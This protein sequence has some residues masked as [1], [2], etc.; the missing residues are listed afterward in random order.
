MV[1]IKVSDEQLVQLQQIQAQYDFLVKRY[2]ELH[3]EA[4]QVDGAMAD[5]II[6]KNDLV[7]SLQ[8]EFGSAGTIDLTTGIFTPE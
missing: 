1:E 7:N 3:F 8:D 2:G 6:L 5:L 4:K